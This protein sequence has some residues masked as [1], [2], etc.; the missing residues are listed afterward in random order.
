MYLVLEKDRGVRSINA[1]LIHVKYFSIF[2]EALLYLDLLCL[3]E[4]ESP[5]NR[6]IGRETYWLQISM[7]KGS[8]FNSGLD[9]SLSTFQHLKKMA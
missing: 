6:R 5:F 7:K 3:G 2:S 9:K 1:A 4:A 8:G